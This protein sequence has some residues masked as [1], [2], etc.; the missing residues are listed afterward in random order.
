[1]FLV[2]TCN[3]G[4]NKPDSNALVSFS[5]GDPAVDLLVTGDDMW[6]GTGGGI[7]RCNL[8]TGITQRYTVLD[9]LGSNVVRK[10]VQDSLGN[11]WATC[12]LAGVSRFDGTRWGNFTVSDGLINNDVITLEADRQGGV[13]VSAY[14][15][16]SYFDGIEWHSFTNM[17]P[18][19]LVVGGENT[20]N[21]DATIIKYVEL[22]AVDVIFIDSQGVIWFSN[23]NKGVTRFDH[24]DW[25]LFSSE[26]GLAEGGVSAIT[27]AKDGNLWFGGMKGIT[28]F[29]GSQFQVLAIKEHQSII[30]RPY[31]QDIR[32]DEQG[33]IWVAAF[34]GGVSCYDGANWRVF[35]SADG[36]PGDNARSIY[37]DSEDNPCVITDKGVGRFNGTRWQILTTEDGL[38]YGEI[39]AVETDDEGN[40]WFGTAEGEIQRFEK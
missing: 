15:G 2:S 21:P 28:C 9:G 36:L 37:L 18:G 33:N 23:R 22:S 4:E 13:W 11:I 6:I 24:E 3:L 29:D 31:I 32:E 30:P 40:I 25:K 12:H 8:K 16:V 5:I 1:M 10:L 20:N 14:W 27:E 19:T 35:T 17:E 26:D 38:P 34:G 7:V 39:K